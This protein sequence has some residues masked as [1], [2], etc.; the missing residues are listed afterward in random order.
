MKACNPMN[1]S[2]GIFWFDGYGRKAIN[3]SEQE[4]VVTKHGRGAGWRPFTTFRRMRKFKGI[5]RVE[6]PYNGRILKVPDSKIKRWP[7][8]GG[9]KS[10]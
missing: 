6:I 3:I 1:Q 10:C 2:V 9:E 8:I 7:T 5:S 4:N